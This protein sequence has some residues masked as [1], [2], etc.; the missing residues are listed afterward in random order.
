MLEA[1][2]I[3]PSVEFPSITR[4]SNSKPFE[5]WLRTDRRHCS[6]LSRSLNSGIITETTG[7]NHLDTWK[8]GESFSARLRRTSLRGLRRR[9]TG[10]LWYHTEDRAE[11][12]AAATQSGKTRVAFRAAL[13]PIT[14]LHAGSTVSPN[15]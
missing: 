1:S 11:F 2:S 9:S 8:C 13:S 15:Q 3:V 14:L 6:M 12:F 5:S 7:F 10:L 4:T